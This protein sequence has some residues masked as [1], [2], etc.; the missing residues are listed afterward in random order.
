MGRRNLVHFR[1]EG[2][3]S[4]AC[5][6]GASLYP[7]AKAVDDITCEHCRKAA[8][9]A[10]APSRIAAL[11]RVAEAAAVVSAALTYDEIAICTVHSDEEA[12]ALRTALAAL[13]RGEP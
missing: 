9:K 1:P 7:I 13:G 2:S 4:M 10:G 6:L 12:T 11:E 3:T 8:V 5:G